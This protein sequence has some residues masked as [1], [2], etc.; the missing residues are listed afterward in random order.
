MV[1]SRTRVVESLHA[2]WLASCACFRSS[3]VFWCFDAW[4]AHCI[5]AFQKGCPLATVQIICKIWD[6]LD[7]ILLIF[8]VRQVVFGF[9]STSF[10]SRWL[11]FLQNFRIKKISFDILIA[12]LW[13]RFLRKTGHSS[14]A[15]AGFRFLKKKHTILT[16]LYSKNWELMLSRNAVDLMFDSGIGYLGQVYWT[17]K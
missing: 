16:L 2:Q 5:T 1:S 6:R 17:N 10:K 12:R 13:P 15:P 3:R 4:E 7:N 14:W 9:P 11:R 8:F